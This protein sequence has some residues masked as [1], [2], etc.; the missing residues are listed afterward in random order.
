MHALCPSINACT[1]VGDT[2]ARP[3]AD[4][5]IDVVNAWSTGVGKV[6]NSTCS[7]KKTGYNE[8]S[9]RSPKLQC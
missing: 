6:Q 9:V 3:A 4:V 1:E 5:S 2:S 8:K 7:K